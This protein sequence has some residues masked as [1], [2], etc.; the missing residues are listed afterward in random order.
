[1]FYPATATLTMKSMRVTVSSDKVE[2]PVAVRYAFENCPE[3]T[4]FNV[5][6]LPA[7]YFRTDD[8]SE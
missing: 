5:E 6:G 7:S 2:N 3:G 1:M 8:W 4:L